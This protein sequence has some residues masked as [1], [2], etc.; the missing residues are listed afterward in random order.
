[1][2]KLMNKL[3][4]VN[5]EINIY[6]RRIPNKL[7]RYCI[8]KE[9]EHYSSLP[10]AMHMK[11]SSREHCGKGEEMREKYFYDGET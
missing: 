11:L 9:E 6:C 2:S 4:Y 8:L 3:I 5:K 7:C 10:R 1:M